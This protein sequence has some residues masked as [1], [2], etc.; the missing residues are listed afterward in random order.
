ME[1][2]TLWAIVLVTIGVVEFFMLL[3]VRRTRQTAARRV[4]EYSLSVEE[5]DGFHFVQLK[6]QTDAG[7]STFELD[8]VYSHVLSDEL[9]TTSTQAL[10]SAHAPK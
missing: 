10:R 2:A 3:R 5:R 1:T 7:R 6:F 8:P 9:L 4:D